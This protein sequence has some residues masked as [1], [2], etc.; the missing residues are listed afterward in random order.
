MTGITPSANMAPM[1][2][3]AIESVGKDTGKKYILL[4][5]DYHNNVLVSGDVIFKADFDKLPPQINN[6][7][8]QL[9][10]VTEDNRLVKVFVKISSMKCFKD[11]FKEMLSS[12]QMKKAGSQEAFFRSIMKYQGMDKLQSLAAT[13][14]IISI[15][16]RAPDG[17]YEYNNHELNNLQ[18]IKV[19]QEIERNKEQW[20]LEANQKGSL[21]EKNISI[22]DPSKGIIKVK[23]EIYPNTRQHVN[24]LGQIDIK[25]KFIGSGTLKR[26][27]ESY[28]YER[29][30]VTAGQYVKTNINNLAR[31]KGE[32]D[33][34]S[35]ISQ[36][37]SDNGHPQVKKNFALSKTIDIA[38]VTKP[39]TA[40][41]PERVYDKVKFT[42]KLNRNGDIYEVLETQTLPNGQ[43]LTPALHKQFTMDILKALDHMGSIGLTHRD[44][45][46]ENIQLKFSKKL[47]RYVAKLAD[48]D[49]ATKKKVDV[50]KGSPPYIAPEV[51]LEMPFDHRSD[52]YSLGK[53]MVNQR[54]LWWM[55]NSA[56]ELRYSELAL[57]AVMGA[58]SSGQPLYYEPQD[59][60][61]YQWFNWKLTHPDINQRFSSA[62]EALTFLENL[63]DPE[64]L[65]IVNM[66]YA[67]ELEDN[68]D[69][70]A[71]VHMIFAQEVAASFQQQ[72][73]QQTA[74]AADLSQDSDSIRSSKR[75]KTDAI[76]SNDK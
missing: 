45:K 43:P 67:M 70:Q 29:G 38:R 37:L 10:L 8:Q 52:L 24:N 30:I 75:Q 32:I 58:L 12:N 56:G 49:L 48:F 60:K 65:K 51:L 16:N 15:K 9:N 27:H 63:P 5:K 31:L 68:A 39:A 23:V 2:F 3:G 62:K 1:V 19:V 11:T 72:Q 50:A 34:Q 61:S 4:L 47:N 28:N 26:V 7:Y 54:D 25:M 66:E 57:H 64:S 41:K 17:S 40:T 74:E 44:I 42:Q 22:P 69:V 76:N 21:L 20:K 46:P 18:I 14:F 6:K 73:Q 13:K 71:Y 59:K 35:E 36:S 55:E 33:N 53:T